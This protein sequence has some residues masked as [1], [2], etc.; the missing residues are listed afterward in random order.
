VKV[1]LYEAGVLH[2]KVC[3]FDDD[4]ATVGTANFDNRSFS[5]NFEITLVFHDADFAQ[6]VADMLIRDFESSTEIDADM[7]AS[8]SLMFR[9]SVQGARLLA[10][11]L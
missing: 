5:L 7:L 4:L 3:V 11:V 8:R 10:P 6:Q 2:Q 9:V 1:L